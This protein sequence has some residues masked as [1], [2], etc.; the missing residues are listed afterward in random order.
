MEIPERPVDLS[1]K[2]G[3]AVG[4]KKVLGNP[5]SAGSE[6]GTEF[7]AEGSRVPGSGKDENGA[8]QALLAMMANGIAPTNGFFKG[9]IEEKEQVEI[10]DNPKTYAAAFL[11]DGLEANQQFQRLMELASRGTESSSGKVSPSEIESGKQ[12]LLPLD[13]QDGQLA[14]TL[15]LAFSLADRQKPDRTEDIIKSFHEAKE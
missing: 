4:V 2:I 13:G 14:A 6:K 11:A 12:A 9:K 5:A 1:T 3:G 15:R 8:G 7:R 10:K